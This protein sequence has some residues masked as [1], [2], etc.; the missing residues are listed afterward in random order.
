[1]GRRTTTT[2]LLAVLA[3][4]LLGA[5]PIDMCVEPSFEAAVA[6]VRLGEHSDMVRLRPRRPEACEAGDG[7]RARFVR[8]GG[9]VALMLATPAGDRLER[10][11]PWL[12]RADDGIVA[13]ARRGRLGAVAVLLDG[14]ILEDRALRAAAAS[15]PIA[16]EP[17]L[18]PAPTAVEAPLTVGASPDAAPEPT[19]K[20]AAPQPSA[21]K[22]VAPKPV[23][24]QPRM[25]SAK[26][27]PQD[28]RTARRAP[29]RAAALAA[30][31]V[32]TA[33]LI[34]RPPPPPEPPPFPEDPAP[35]PTIAVV[36]PPPPAEQGLEGRV[37]A[38]LGAALRAP[39]VLGLE[40]ALQL[41][42]ASA[43]AEVGGMAPTEWALDSRPLE[44]AAAWAG[45]GWVPRLWGASGLHV[46]G[47]LMGVI[48]RWTVLRVGVPGAVTRALWDAGLEL[49]LGVGGAMGDGWRVG[50]IVGG[51]WM[52][53]AN[54]V[55]IPDGP[56][57]ALNAWQIR[58]GFSIDWRP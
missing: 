27:E 11:V 58:L 38:R 33:A 4:G 46:D 56:R 37:G 16:A 23:A 17:P 13:L 32:R 40:V 51:R 41:H 12:E 36:A 22:P 45:A 54:D 9:G 3:I 20:P 10:A 8:R 42:L 19:P 57:A 48:E 35:P 55:L 1:M 52:A 44:I 47:R 5:V 24:P 15:P 29:A 6:V 34:T 7:Y 21:P 50:G 25:R 49:G 26:P 53:T 30:R 2:G 39:S 28:P 14:L 43:M 18:A 31:D